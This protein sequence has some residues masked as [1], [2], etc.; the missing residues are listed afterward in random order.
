MVNVCTFGR[1][2]TN[3]GLGCGF[4]LVKG[5]RTSQAFEGMS[6]TK[7]TWG[8]LRCRS[9]LCYI[10]ESV[11]ISELARNTSNTALRFTN[12]FHIDRIRCFSPIP[13]CIFPFSFRTLTL[14]NKISDVTS[15]T[16]ALDGGIS[17]GSRMHSPRYRGSLIP[18]LQQYD[19]SLDYQF[20]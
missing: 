9:N 4:S 11:C 2:C 16:Q 7:S 13:G 19:P 1:I 15:A 17:A 20:L 8:L 3:Q 14:V 6:A 18:I 5:Q 12:N 10:N